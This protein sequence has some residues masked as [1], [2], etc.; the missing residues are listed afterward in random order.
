MAEY[1]ESLTRQDQLDQ[2]WDQFSEALAWN[3][4]APGLKAWFYDLFM[5]D[6]RSC[7]YEPEPVIC[8]GCRMRLDTPP[9]DDHQWEFRYQP[10]E[11]VRPT[12][13]YR[14]TR[15]HLTVP[16][17]YQRIPGAQDADADE[18]EARAGRA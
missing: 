13:W 15:C 17:T 16:Q 10:D 14:C 2:E 18:P 8:P 12:I 6:V 4:K 1:R 11:G 7:G 3:P 5:R 9:L